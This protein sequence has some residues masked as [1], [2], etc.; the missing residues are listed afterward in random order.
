M[1]L[2]SDVSVKVYN[3]DTNEVESMK[4]LRLNQ[5]NK[6]NNEMGSVDV[7]DQLRGV[8][9]MDRWVCNREWW[10][11]MLFWSVGVLLTNAYKLYLR[12]CEDEGVIPRYKEQFEF[13]KAIA[14]YWINPEL[15]EKERLQGARKRKY[16]DDSVS[17]MSPITNPFM[18]PMD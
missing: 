11:S 12:V 4:F 2:R 9:R 5:I 18:S 3:V 10:W 16:D 8:Y 1:L 17:C 7:A 13:R 6:Y 14:E 15:I